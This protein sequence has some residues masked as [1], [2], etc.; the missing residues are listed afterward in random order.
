MGLISCVACFLEIGSQ[1]RHVG[2]VTL[3]D[4]SK[5]LSLI[6]GLARGAKQIYHFEWPALFQPAPPAPRGSRP[7]RGGLASFRVAPRFAIPRP[8][9]TYPRP[10]SRLEELVSGKKRRGHL[11][12][13][14]VHENRI[15]RR[16]G[17]LRAC[18]EA[19]RNVGMAAVELAVC[20]CSEDV[21]LFSHTHAHTHTHS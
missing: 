3:C 1:L 4:T 6:S 13:P 17:S 2:N 9:K 21:L 12:S 7:L 8:R 5:Q 14:S 11:V 20:G 16:H 18:S 15:G 19:S 10:T